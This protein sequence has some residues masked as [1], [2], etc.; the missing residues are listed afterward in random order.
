MSL[1]VIIVEDEAA[2]ARNLQRVLKQV[3]PAAIIDHVLTSVDEAKAHF[4]R[5]A[6]GVELLLMD[7]QLGDGRSLELLP[8][9]YPPVPIIFITAHDEFALQAFAGD[10][11]AY[12][13]KPV[14]PQE[15][16]AALDKY[17]RLVLRHGQ[18]TDQAERVPKPHAF[19]AHHRGQFVPLSVD[20]M[21]YIRSEHEITRVHSF[22]GV[23]LILDETLERLEHMLPPE[24]FFRLNRQYIASRP[25]I[26]ALE[27]YFNGRMIAKLDPD[28][29]E[30]V[31]VSKEKAPLLKRWLLG[32]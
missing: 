1:H 30:Q 9:I 11:I 19:L 12:I 2:T 13:L 28:A 17:E 31:F 16:A 21:A 29:P 8:H 32:G 26:K 5:G 3:R 23:R 18:A 7:I 6:H 15:L 22:D 24:S 14:D 20:R 25:A 4:L 10:G 27:P